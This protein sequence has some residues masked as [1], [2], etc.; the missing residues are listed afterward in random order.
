MHGRRAADPVA[1]L[2]ASANEAAEVLGRT[3]DASVAVERVAGH[4]R[5][6]WRREMRERLKAHVAAGG[7]GLSDLAL[8]ASLRL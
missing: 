8:R 2:V 6:Q 3:A 5:R 4:L 1:R 7:R